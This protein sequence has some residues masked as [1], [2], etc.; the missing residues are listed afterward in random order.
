V[1]RY[2]EMFAR[3]KQRNEGAFGGFLMLGD[4]DIET[5]ARLLDTVVEAGADMIEVGIP[6]SDPVADGPVI[7]AAAERALANGIRVDDSFTLIRQL[8]DKHPAV[9]IGILTYANLLSARGREKFM[10]D[11]AEAGADSI[12]IADVPSLEAVPYSA[13][14]KAAGLDL[15]MIAAPNTPRAVV[16]RIAELS[17]GYTYCVARAGVTGTSTTLALDHDR[18]FADLADAG[19]PPPVLGFGIST[20]EQVRE[21]LASGAAGV[22]AGSALVKC[23]SDAAALGQLVSALKD[24]TGL[25]H[26]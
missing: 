6:F 12:L 1:S 2:D 4:P 19:A 22:I 3:L 14:A 8:R 10:T 5:S 7:Q 21:A 24:A 9:P 11:A 20:P 18:L 16:D 25:S 23:G 15:V 26:N 13:A 17:S